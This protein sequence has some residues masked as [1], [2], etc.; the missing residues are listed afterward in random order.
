[1]NVPEKKLKFKTSSHMIDKSVAM[2]TCIAF[3]NCK[4]LA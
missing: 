1:M 4:S 3:E 2:M